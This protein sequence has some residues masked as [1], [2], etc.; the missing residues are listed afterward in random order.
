MIAWIGSDSVRRAL[1]ALVVAIVAWGGSHL[2]ARGALQSRADGFALQEEARTRQ[3]TVATAQRTV[4]AFGARHAQ[5][6]A[7]GI[8][9]PGAPGWGEAIESMARARGF[10]IDRATP[11]VARIDAHVIADVYPADL[12]LT[13][14]HEGEFLALLD[15]LARVTPGVLYVRTCTLARAAHGRGLT[16]HCR[17][18]RLVVR[19]EEE[20]T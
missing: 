3:Y 6:R 9:G 5:L 16:A 17:L 2:W 8:V 12:R 4:A 10:S 1:T 11:Q 14:R 13:T 19:A 15:E 20:Q 18:E 7:R